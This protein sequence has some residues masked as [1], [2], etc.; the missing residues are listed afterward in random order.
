MQG[1]GSSDVEHRNTHCLGGIGKPGV[2]REHDIGASTFGSR[3][4][5]CVK[6]SELCHLV[7]RSP[8]EVDS[9][10]LNDHHRVDD[11]RRLGHRK[12]ESYRHSLKFGFE[13]L[14]RENNVPVVE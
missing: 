7:S 5:Q 12:P 11:I 2:E 4:V 6:A 3:Q 8:S 13:D 1:S 10:M 14:A 9:L